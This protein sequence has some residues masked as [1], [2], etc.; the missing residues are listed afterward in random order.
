CSSVRKTRCPTQGAQS[1]PTR[2]APWLIVSLRR[3]LSGVTSS[4]LPKAH[5]RSPCLLPEAPEQAARLLLRWRRRFLHLL[6]LRWTR[7]G[8]P[9]WRTS[10]R[11]WRRRRFRRFGLLCTDHGVFRI[12]AAGQPD[13]IDRMLDRVQAGACRE[14]P[15]RENPLHFTLQG[16]FVDL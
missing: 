7:R 10:L 2:P 13:V 5:F 12:F 16:D 14:H 9:W 6:L 3:A 8:L 1:T 15:A 11:G 4:A